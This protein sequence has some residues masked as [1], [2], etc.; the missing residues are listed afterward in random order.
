VLVDELDRCDPDEAFNVIKQMRV[1]FAMRQLPVAFVVCAN[2]EPIGLAIKHRYGLESENGDY[3]ARRIL[4]KFVDAYED[5]S[6]TAPLGEFVTSLWTERKS[7]L[8]WLLRFDAANGGAEYEADTVHNATALDAMNTSVPLYSNLRVLLKSFAY[9]DERASW[10]RHLLWTIWHLEIVGQLD[11]HFRRALRMLAPT[12][13]DIA[14][15]SY[16][17][18]GGIRYSVEQPGSGK[19]PFLKYETDKGKTLFSIYR[20]LF[21]ENAKATLATLRSASEPREKVRGGDLEALL[22]DTR[23]MDF[24]IVLS[25]LSFQG[26]K[27]PA[28]LM[29]DAQRGSLPSVSLEP[30]DTL[31]R[32]FGWLL[33]NY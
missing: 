7:E 4:E 17:N 23:R 24:V 32:Q 33:A 6:E 27:F 1:L 19:T 9:V 5:L 13:E 10:N 11:P 2:P 14:S 12:I 22:T 31:R 28:D 18:L 29:A 25:L 3:E 20:S 16:K 26:M 30:R 8:P 21:W 15:V